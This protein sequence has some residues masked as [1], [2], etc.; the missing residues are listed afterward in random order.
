MPLS[1]KFIQFCTHIIR[2]SQQPKSKLSSIFYYNAKCIQLSRK[3]FIKFS[4]KSLIQTRTHPEFYSINI[5]IILIFVK[6]KK[7]C[8]H[9]LFNK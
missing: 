7:P 3:F 1:A 4:Q 8:T 6:N 2:K 5:F 9:L